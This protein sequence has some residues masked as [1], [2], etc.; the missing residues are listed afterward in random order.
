V[1]TDDT[2]LSLM[3]SDTISSLMIMVLCHKNLNRS[4]MTSSSSRMDPPAS[5]AQTRKAHT[6]SE[7]LAAFTG[8]L[9][10]ETVFRRLPSGK[11]SKETGFQE[12]SHVGLGVDPD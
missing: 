3:I 1:I 8:K 10:S 4:G 6:D 12:G 11:C 5:P 2:I 7:T 9:L